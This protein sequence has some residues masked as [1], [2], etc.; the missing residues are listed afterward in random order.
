[1][2]DEGWVSGHESRIILFAPNPFPRFVLF[3]AHPRKRTTKRRMPL[4]R[5]GGWARLSRNVDDKQNFVWF[6][7]GS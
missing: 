1:M 4:K 2:K 6:R 7:E 5:R 3:L